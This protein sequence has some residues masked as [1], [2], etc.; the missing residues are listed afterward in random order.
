MGRLNF[1]LKSRPLWQHLA[2]FSTV[3]KVSFTD[4][5]ILSDASQNAVLVIPAGLEDFLAEVGQLREHPSSEPPALSP[6][7]MEKFLVIAPDY[8]LEIIPS[9]SDFCNQP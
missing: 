6:T 2:L 8:G 9:P 5:Q 4:L 1:R 7:D 3:Q